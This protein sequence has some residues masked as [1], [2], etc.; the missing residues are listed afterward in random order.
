MKSK[1]IKTLKNL[2]ALESLTELQLDE[3]IK[4][5]EGKAH[6]SPFEVIR[7]NAGIFDASE[8]MQV[9]SLTAD[10]QELLETLKAKAK[11]QGVKV[12]YLV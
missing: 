4:A 8:V 5:I 6:P 9:T 11:L 10:E 1:K 7:K 3:L 2:L 12:I